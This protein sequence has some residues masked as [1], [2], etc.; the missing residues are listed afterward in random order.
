MIVGTVYL[1]LVKVALY[2]KSLVGI[3]AILSRLPIKATKAL[4]QRVFTDSSDIAY[5]FIPGKS[6]RLGT[7]LVDFSSIKDTSTSTEIVNKIY[8]YLGSQEFTDT[9]SVKSIEASIIQG[10]LGNNSSA[11]SSSQTESSSTKVTKLNK[12][13]QTPSPQLRERSGRFYSLNLLTQLIKDSL[14]DKVSSLMGTGSS[15]KVLNY[16]SGRFAESVEVKTLSQGRTGMITA[17]YTYMKYP[18]QTFEPGFAQGHIAS[19]DPKLL[20]AKAIREIAATRVKN[21]MRA[22]LI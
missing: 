11:S 8:Q 10:L 14:L 4:I 22:V 6:S 3:S 20:I 1:L 2:T 7:V 12:V 5:E 17:F 19:R 18:Y 15:R 16:R 21:R 13:R 9:L